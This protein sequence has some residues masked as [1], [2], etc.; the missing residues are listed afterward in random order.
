MNEESAAHYLK[1]N[2]MEMHLGSIMLFVKDMKSVIAFYRD[3]VGLVPEEDQP[4]PEH[5]FFRFDTGAC[6]LCL[7]SASKPNEG[8]QKL[9][10]HVKSVSA[11]HQ[12]LKSKGKRLRKLENEDG[13]A[14]FDIR[15]PEGNRIQ[16]H[17]NY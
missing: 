1:G 9:V 8:R 12:H 15:D 17:G 16:F 10:F 2:E 5:R 14:I 13:R 3:V 4:F 11:V 7:H 6:K